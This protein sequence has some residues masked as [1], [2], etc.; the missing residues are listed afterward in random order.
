MVE[1]HLEEQM[2]KMHRAQRD[3]WE[4]ENEY[5][6]FLDFTAKTESTSGFLILPKK[7]QHGKGDSNRDQNVQTR[8]IA[9]DQGT[10]T[11]QTDM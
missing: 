11:I 1:N 9:L 6:H 5:C 7:R 8:L 3:Y 2:E 4:M 10:K